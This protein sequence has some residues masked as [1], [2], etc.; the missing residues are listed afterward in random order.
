MQRHRFFTAFA[1]PLILAGCGAGANPAVDR[2]AEENAVAQASDAVVAAES[3][4]DTEGALAYWA[5]DA[6]LHMQS[7][8]EMVGRDAV[9]SVYRSMFGDTTLLG[10]TST[11]TGIELAAGGALAL[12]HGLNHF[13]VQGPDGPMTN[14]GKYL[15]VWR[16]GDDGWKI[17]ALA[18]T[19]NVPPL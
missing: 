14:E 9:R 4:R 5:D 2:A 17:A 3:A 7:A 6:I 13:R 19:D 15:L 16:K 11:R 1:F 10:F 18:V 12:E 8:P